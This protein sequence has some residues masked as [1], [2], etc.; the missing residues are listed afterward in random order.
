MHYFIRDEINNMF[1]EH[2]YQKRPPTD[3]KKVQV[4]FDKYADL[5]C[6]YACSY[7]NNR[8]EA[9]DVV[10]EIFLRILK[11]EEFLLSNDL[12]VKTYLLNAVR[13][14][15]INLLKKKNTV[16]YTADIINYQILDEEFA[17]ID[18][19][20]IQ[21]LQKE[22]FE[23]P[24][25]TQ[26][27]IIGIFYRSLKYKEIAAELNISVNTVKSLLEAGIKKLRKNLGSDWEIILFLWCLK[28]EGN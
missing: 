19:K 13:N 12:A 27:I 14:S 2:T 25:Q 3:K 20:V 16:F 7:L 8:D 4:Y 5:I 21:Q 28:K 18:E 26:K 17:T 24:P 6:N 23:L 9:E 22:I 15:C 11:K 1:G 10:Q